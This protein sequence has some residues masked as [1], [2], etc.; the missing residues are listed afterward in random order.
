MKIKTL[1][2]ILFVLTISKIKAQ[3]IIT[4][5]N[6]EK[7]KVIIKK[8]EKNNIKYVNF[9]DPNGVLFT[10]DK[11]LISEVKFAYGEKLEVK[12]PEEDPF[13]FTED[14]INNI[15]FNFSAFANNTLGL[16]Y[17][18]SI[19]LGH[20]IMGEIKVYG[21]GIKQENEKSRNGIGLDFYYRLK[22]QSLF[23]K[24]EYRP[25]HILSGSY[26]SP[27][28]GFSTGELYYK[29]HTIT[30]KTSHTL[31][32]FGIQYGN[33][34]IIQRKVSVDASFGFHYYIGN[35]KG[36]DNEQPIKLGNM[37]GEENKLFSFNLRVGFLVGKKTYIKK[38][39]K[40]ELKK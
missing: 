11:V 33:Q 7:L 26:F 35:T 31:V 14:K 10:I 30:E 21:L 8:V 15:M 38:S 37:L 1:I 28:V 25:N 19:K 24:G 5:K 13:Y 36:N 32:H 16:A 6:G 3:D 20:S 18:K 12:N 9:D 2:I 39:E 17:E 4:K 29:K 22:T 23:N 27:I 34:W 40:G